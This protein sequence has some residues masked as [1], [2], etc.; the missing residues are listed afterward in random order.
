MSVSPV[1]YSGI[2]FQ[3]NFSTNSGPDTSQA[4]R[5]GEPIEVDCAKKLSE[6]RRSRMGQAS[7]GRHA[8]GAAARQS[9]RRFEFDA[10]MV[11]AAGFEPKPSLAIAL[12]AKPDRAI[13]GESQ[14]RI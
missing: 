6:I 13:A 2:I 12:R 9:D 7:E 4:W 14:V 8:A 5:Q 1:L 11:G 3:I 10:S